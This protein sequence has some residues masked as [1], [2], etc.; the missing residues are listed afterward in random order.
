MDIGGLSLELDSFVETL[1]E[2]LL[3]RYDIDDITEVFK[4]ILQGQPILQPALRTHCTPEHVVNVISKFDCLQYEF[5]IYNRKV[6]IEKKLC[7]NSYCMR[8]QNIYTKHEVDFI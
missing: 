3:D 1:V 2:L 4:D 6:Q 5:P 8:V 7:N